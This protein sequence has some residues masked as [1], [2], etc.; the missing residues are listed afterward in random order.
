MFVLSSASVGLLTITQ[1]LLVR[2]LYVNKLSGV[3]LGQHTLVARRS[4]RARVSLQA[5][6]IAKPIRFE[7]PSQ[8]NALSENDSCSPRQQTDRLC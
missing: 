2:T 3:V 7:P 4:S 5:P 1:Q 6:G 8:A